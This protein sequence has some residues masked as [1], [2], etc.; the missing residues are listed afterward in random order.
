[1]NSGSVDMEEDAECLKMPDTP[2]LVPEKD[3]EAIVSWTSVKI[4]EG[5]PV[6]F[7]LDGAEYSVVLLVNKRY[8]DQNK[9]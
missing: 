9:I 6:F 2:D 1:M 5:N 8:L 7:L 3:I 4:Y